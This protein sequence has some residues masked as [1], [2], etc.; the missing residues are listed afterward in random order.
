[1]VA[2]CHER[3]SHQIGEQQR[4]LVVSLVAIRGHASG[5]TVC[6]GSCCNSI[7]FVGSVLD[8]DRGSIESQILMM[9]PIDSVYNLICVLSDARCFDQG[10]IIKAGRI[11]LD[12]SRTC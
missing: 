8:N 4:T 5:N 3:K 11:M 10:E 12:W 6:S 9:K 1:M 2:Q 7:V